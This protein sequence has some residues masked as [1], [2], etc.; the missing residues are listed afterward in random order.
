[1]TVGFAAAV[2]RQGNA[3]ADFRVNLSQLLTKICAKDA[4]QEISLDFCTGRD[5][6]ENGSL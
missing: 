4:T 3:A 5:Y 1:M 2:F 6:H